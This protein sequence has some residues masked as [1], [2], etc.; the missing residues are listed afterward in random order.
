VT[1]AAHFY[2]VSKN[3]IDP[4]VDAATWHLRVVGMVDRPLDLRY[5]DLLALP[6]QR[7]YQT[8]ECISNEVGGTLMSNGHWTGVQLGDLLRRAGIQPGATVVNFTSVDG[9]TENMP[10]DKALLPETLLAYQLNDAPLA[11]KHGFPA[12]ILGTGTYG[13]KNPKWLTEIAVGRS[14]APGFWEQQGWDAAAIV[15]TT[16]R[17]DQ[18][19]DGSTMSGPSVIAGLAFAGDRGIQRVEVSTDG[20]ATWEA[21]RLIP[22]LGPSTWVFWQYTWSPAQ[23]GPYQLVVRATDGQGQ[24]Q[25]SIATDTYPDGATGY[26]QIRVGVQAQAAA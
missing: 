5:A 25:T 24:L 12:R 2:V 15:K 21:A 7:R 1:P 6:A 23:D 18:P 17:I 11:P 10:I 20:G 22:P 26:D 3:I 14:A 13:M 8:L 4:T 9:Y 16:S 19:G